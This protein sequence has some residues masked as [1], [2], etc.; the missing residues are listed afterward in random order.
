MLEVDPTLLGAPDDEDYDSA[1]YD[2]STASLSSSVHQYLFEHGRR[3]HTYYGP[4]KYLI[5]TDEKE[6]D[7]LDLHHEI[8]RML[9][10]DRLHECPLH[11]PHQILDIDTG[12]GIWAI[13][14]AD[15]YPMAEIIGTHLSPIQPEWVPANCRFEVDDAMSEWTFKDDFFD[16]IHGRNIGSGV[17]NWDHLLSEMICCVNPR[18]YVELCE[19]SITINCDDGTMKPDNGMKLYMDSLRES[20]TKMVRPPPNV[21]YLTQLPQ[22]AGFEEIY[23]SE[24]KEPVGPWPKDPRQKRIGAMVLLNCETGLES[25]GMAAFTGVLGMEDEK[26]RDM[27]DAAHYH[28]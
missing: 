21:G 11:Q 17:S 7:R 2:T 22:K 10:D 4:E 24:V 9:W 8:M 23:S 27:C 6:Q 1:G 12:T 15:Q 20:M 25:Y 14:M 19:Y 28:M 5:P 13:E 18:G 16:F 3:Y 26:A